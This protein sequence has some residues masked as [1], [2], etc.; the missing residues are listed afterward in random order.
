[1]PETSSALSAQPGSKAYHEHSQRVAVSVTAVFFRL[2]TAL[3]SLALHPMLPSCAFPAPAHDAFASSTQICDPP[4]TQCYHTLQLRNCMH[5]ALN[6]PTLSLSFLSPTTWSAPH[7]SPLQPSQKCVRVFLAL[8]PQK[9]AHRTSLVPQ[10]PAHRTSLAPLSYPVCLAP[11]HMHAPCPTCLSLPHALPPLP[12][13]AP[14]LAP[15]KP[16]FALAPLL[17]CHLPHCESLNASTLYELTGSGYT[18]VYSIGSH[19]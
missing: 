6:H 13:S 10:K 5:P 14:C 2:D 1:M 17:L 11:T 18:V 4:I 19:M 7:V 15:D 8:V 3:H 16:T 12:F 9:L